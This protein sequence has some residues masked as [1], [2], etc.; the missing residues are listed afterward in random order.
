MKCGDIWF[1]FQGSLTL[2]YSVQQRFCLKFLE[3]KPACGSV[4]V[5]AEGGTSSPCSISS[6]KFMAGP[7]IS[8]PPPGVLMPCRLSGETVQAK[9]STCVGFHLHLWASFSCP[10]TLSRITGLVSLSGIYNPKGHTLRSLTCGH[11]NFLS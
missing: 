11:R 5:F 8:S 1:S 7:A 4:L 9:T 10:S 6:L 2:T 3:Q